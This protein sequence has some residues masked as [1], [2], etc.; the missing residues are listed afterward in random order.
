[1]INV[2]KKLGGVVPPYEA[3]IWVQCQGREIFITKSEAKR[4]ITILTEL[5][6]EDEG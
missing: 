2:W 3:C 5:M 6:E 1:M 4:L